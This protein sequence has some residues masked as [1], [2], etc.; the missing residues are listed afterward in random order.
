M[1]Q[2]FLTFVNWK[3]PGFIGLLKYI[4]LFGYCRVFGKRG[5]GEKKFHQF[6]HISC[7]IQL[8]VLQIKKA[9]QNQFNVNLTNGKSA[10][11]LS[12]QTYKVAVC[13][14]EPFQESL[15]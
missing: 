14:R 1:R 9:V 10:F 6:T 2:I 4:L 5:L 13:I 8:R 3:L 7:I 15:G 11:V 12:S